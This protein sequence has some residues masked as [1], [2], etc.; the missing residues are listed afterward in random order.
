MSKSIIVGYSRFGEYNTLVKAG[1]YE[2]RR[3]KKIYKDTKYVE[4]VC[5]GQDADNKAY[6]GRLNID[7]TWVLF[8]AI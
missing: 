7:I 2:Y 3:K 5:M 6:K 1:K 8:L 4:C